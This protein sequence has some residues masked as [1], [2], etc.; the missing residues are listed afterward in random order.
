MLKN[1]G[2]MMK[3]EQTNMGLKQKGHR[4]PDSYRAAI[5]KKAK[6]IH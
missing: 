5:Q 6:L 1:N 4:N 2:N 3:Y